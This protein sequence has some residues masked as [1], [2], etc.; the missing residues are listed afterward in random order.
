MTDQT[1]PGMQFQTA[2]AT[3]GAF[4][5]MVHVGVHVVLKIKAVSKMGRGLGL[6]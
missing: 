2:S 4:N 5:E 1:S 6:L 3:P